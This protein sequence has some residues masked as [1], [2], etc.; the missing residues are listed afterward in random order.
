MPRVVLDRSKR[1]AMRL[2][3]LHEI[4]IDIRLPEQPAL[5]GE[6]SADC[7]LSNA[8]LCADLPLR[9]ALSG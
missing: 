5:S 8:K 3:R 7:R 2:Q 6:D 4:W 1:R 9:L